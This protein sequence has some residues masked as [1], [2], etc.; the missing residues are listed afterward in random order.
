[1][2]ADDP[3]DAL[4]ASQADVLGE[5][6]LQGGADPSYEGCAQR[7]PELLAYTFLANEGSSEVIYVEP[8]GRL[9]VLAGEF[10]PVTL[11]HALFDPAKLLPPA[12]PNRAVRRLIAGWLPAIDFA[13]TDGK[14]GIAW[15]QTAFVAPTR[16]ELYVAF[17]SV[18]AGTGEATVRFRIGAEGLTPVAADWFDARQRELEGHW[19]TAFA[20]A[21]RIE[22]PEAKVPKACYASLARALVTHDGP[23]PRYGVGLYRNPKDDHFPPATLSTVN[24]CVEWNLFARA[25]AHLDHYLDRVLRPDGTFDYYG[26]AVSEYGQMLDAMARYARRSRDGAWLCGRVPEAERIVAHLLALHRQGLKWPR[27]DPR[28]GLLFGSGEADTREE[29]DFYYAS[30]AWAWRG[31]LELARAYTD[32]GDEAMRGRA[33]ELRAEAKALRADLDAS[34]AKSVVPTP[35]GPFVPPVPCFQSPFPTMTAD[36]F[37]SYT[38]YRYWPEMLGAVCL[39][40][41]WHDAILAYRAA[42]GGE[43]LGTTRFLDRLDDWPYAACARGLLAR[44]RIPRFLLGFYGHLAA[45]CTQ[46]TY[47]AYEQ[48][49]IR[50][51]PTRT[52]VADYCVPAQLVTPLMARWMLVDEEPDAEVLW[53]GRAV[54]RQWLGAGQRLSVRRAPTRWGLIEFAIETRGD[55]SVAARVVLPDRGLPAELRLRLRR[56]GPTPLSAIAVNGQPHTHLDPTGETIHIVRPQA[57]TLD[58]VAR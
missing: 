34:I 56:P 29:T 3:A 17:K 49:A 7:L 11:D 28:R 15:Q 21:T 16:P 6:M 48:V 46:G 19:G 26:P 35:H 20:D 40:P 30:S 53:L 51:T 27:D 44:D 43:L 14:N 8:D 18:R 52:C 24:A 54:P 32:L 9:G 36:R 13:F 47:T 42:R 23:K 31:L 38:N 39:R 55:G 10:G 12:Q 41:E 4:L 1:M 45:H 5:Q 57:T 33:Q 22:V 2:P 50:G 37:A 25:R 58:I